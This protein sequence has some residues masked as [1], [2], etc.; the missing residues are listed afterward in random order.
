VEIFLFALITIAGAMLQDML[1]T[2]EESVLSQ[3][4]YRQKHRKERSA[5]DGD[6]TMQIDDTGIRIRKANSNGKG[7]QIE[8]DENGIRTK[9]DIDLSSGNSSPH[10]RLLPPAAQRRSSPGK[11]RRCANCEKTGRQRHP[12]QASS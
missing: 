10:P 1:F 4:T 5:T 3:K 7:K 12:Y 11:T 9:S 2:S 6:T 8:I